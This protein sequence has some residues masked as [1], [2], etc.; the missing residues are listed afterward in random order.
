MAADPDSFE[1][2]CQSNDGILSGN[3]GDDSDDLEEVQSLLTSIQSTR[4][5]QRI[6]NAMGNEPAALLPPASVTPT[7]N[8]VATAEPS[9]LRVV[10]RDQSLT[11]IMSFLP[12]AIWLSPWSAPPAPNANLYTVDNF[13]SKVYHEAARPNF[14]ARLRVHG[15]NVTEMA[16]ILD[17][18]LAVA[19]GQNDFSEVLSPAQDF[20]IMGENGTLLST[21]P[22]IEHEVIFTAFESYRSFVGE[23]HPETRAK[24][25]QWLD[26]GSNGDITPFQNHLAAYNALEIRDEGAHKAFAAD[27]LYCMIFGPEPPYHP[28]WKAFYRGFLLSCHNG[29]S[30]LSVLVASFQARVFVW[31]ITGS[32][33]IDPGTD[34]RIS[35][36][37]TF[38]MLKAAT[39]RGS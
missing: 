37:T 8:A 33:F 34:D 4:T 11:D 23:W 18:K 31:A 26:I 3:D 13:D 30:F 35:R 15:R 1:D 2:D 17:A 36:K 6:H 27:M 22:G 29:F 21:G 20:Q 19:V 5:E 14:S 16:S 10:L 9:S 38:I 12:P 24:V 25:L 32:P 7:I 39:R 28:E